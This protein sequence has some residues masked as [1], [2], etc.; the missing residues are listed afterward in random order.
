MPQ[1]QV[2]FYCDAD[3]SAP[4]L[5]WLD[6]LAKSERRAF[7]KCRQA[8]SMLETFGFELRRPHADMLRDG[9]YELRTRVGSVNYRLLYFFHGQGVAIL[10]HGL[11]KE[12]AVPAA[13]ID[14][15]INRKRMFEADPER[16]SYKE[17]QP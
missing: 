15:A 9:V 14:R 10:T 6:Q 13:E 1:T 4:V 7:N 11:T 12:K 17:D 2:V 3:G 5:A 8:I 16:H